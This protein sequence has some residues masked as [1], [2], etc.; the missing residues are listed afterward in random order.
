LLILSNGSIVAGAVTPAGLQPAAT[1]VSG[2][3]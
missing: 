2:T 1:Q 3:Q